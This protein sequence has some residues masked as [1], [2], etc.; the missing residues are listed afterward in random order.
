MNNELFWIWLSSA[1]GVDTESYALL[2]EFGWSPYNVY[3][4]SETEILQKTDWN[5]KKVEKLKSFPIERAEE[6]LRLSNENGWSVITPPD[7]LFPKRLLKFTNPPLA[8]YVAGNEKALRYDMSLSIVGARKATDYGKA[9]ARAIASILAELDFTIVSGGALGVD[10]A[11]HTGALDMDKP[12]ICV[13]G[14]GLGTRYLMDNEPMRRKITEKGAVISEFPPFYPASRFTFPKRNRIISGMTLGTV[15]VEAGEK[16]G[17]LITADCAF[18]Q[19]KHVFAV[20][21]DLVSSS[22]V[23]TNNLIRN[24]AIPVFSHNDIL[25]PLWSDYSEFLSKHD[26]LPDGEI[27]RRTQ[28]YLTP[29]EKPK[30]PAPSSLSIK[31]E[32]VFSCLSA[33]PLHIDEIKNKS[34]LSIT[35]TL[36]AVTELEMLGLAVQLSGRRYKIK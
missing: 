19:G 2:S 16:S 8:L 33:E 17:S 31:A 30:E 9:V 3:C 11:A 35:E 14:C 5:R 28:G 36:S 4:A 24:G 21:G 10:S 6:F 22:Y 20:P 25:E 15:V 32:R 26:R 13:M 23:G 27:V 1:L 29:E 18:K 34:G 7:K 12:T